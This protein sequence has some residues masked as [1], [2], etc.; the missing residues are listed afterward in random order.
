MKI[1]RRKSAILAIVATTAIGGGAAF[2]YWTQSGTGTGTATAGTT[3]GITV[4]QTG[5][6]TGLYP[7]GT[8][9]G[10]SG[11]FTNTNTGPVS[12]SSITAAVAA[13]TT[14]TP[15][16]LKPP[17]TQAD[18]AISGTSG[19][20]IAPAGTEVGSWSG[21]SVAL[22]AGVANQD[23]CK[24]QAITINYTANP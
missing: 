7:G 18:F 1:T 13:F 21:L 5:S 15:D 4:N 23:N 11:T 6:V 10:L 9:I 20:N 8:P 2:A 16:P 17:C 22:V 24:G 14:V 19:A 12:I 3:T